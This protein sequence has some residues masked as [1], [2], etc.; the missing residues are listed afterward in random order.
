MNDLNGR[1]PST[2]TDLQKE[3]P[4]VGKYTAGILRIHYYFFCGLSDFDVFNKVDSYG[5]MNT[6]RN[7]LFTVYLI[8]SIK[9]NKQ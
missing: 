8:L 9:K 7:L 2:S 1:I 3:L 4:G 6:A 5:I